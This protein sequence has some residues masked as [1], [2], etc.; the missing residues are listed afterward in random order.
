MPVRSKGRLLAGAGAAFALCFGGSGCLTRQ[1]RPEAEPVATPAVVTSAPVPASRF[2]FFRR[3]PAVEMQAPVTAVADRQSDVAQGSNVIASAWRPI[4]RNGGAPQQ[5]TVAAS[6]APVTDPRLQQTGANGADAPPADTPWHPVVL[7]AGGQPA[8]SQTPPEQ[9]AAPA[10]AP[11]SPRLVPQ[12]VQSV[13][14]APVAV[15]A[16]V[17]AHTHYH[18]PFG[19]HA[20]PPP[21]PA[22]PREF[23]KQSLPP[24]IVEPPDILLINASA[25]ISLPTQPLI[26][27]HLVRPDGTINLGIYGSVYVAGLT[28]DQVQDVVASVLLARH[29]KKKDETGKAIDMSV[30]D[31]KLELQVDVLAYNSKVYYIITDGGGYGEQVYR[32]SAT[33]NETVLDALSQING[34]PAVASKKRIWVARATPDHSPPM[35]L[36][37]DWCGIVRNGSAATNYQIFPGDRIYVNSDAFIRTDSG[38]GKFLA[39]VERVLGTVLLGSSTVNSIRNSNTSNGNGIP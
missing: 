26:G 9:I 7:A 38:L 18:Y 12:S 14:P 17:V 33:G 28:L 35:I 21:V 8:A 6:P 20:P 15:Q 36:P 30:Q 29:A 11:P 31:I 4:D 24:Y 1:V 23:E 34:L 22:V 39:P 3:R 13:Q 16:P 5:Q 19:V 32:I 2:S 37:V 25:A 27:Q 10:D